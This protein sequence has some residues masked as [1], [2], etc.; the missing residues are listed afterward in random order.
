MFPALEQLVWSS[1][2]LRWQILS[3]RKRGIVASREMHNLTAKHTEEFS[4]G[5]DKKLL[6]SCQGA[7]GNFNPSAEDGPGRVL[8]QTQPEGPRSWKGWD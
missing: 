4:G 8:G 7:L 2:R 5:E 1:P 6:D 3:P